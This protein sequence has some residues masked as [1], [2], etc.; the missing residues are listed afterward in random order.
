MNKIPLGN[1][2]EVRWRI[3]HGGQAESL[4]GLDLILLMTT[5]SGQIRQMPF[6]ISELNLITMPFEGK[7]QGEIGGYRLDLYENRDLESQYRIDSAP[8]FILV[9]HTAEGRRETDPNLE[10]YTVELEGNIEVGT[11]SNAVTFTPS[12]SAM[13]RRNKLAPISTRRKAAIPE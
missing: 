11:P 12:C 6:V 3:N 7:E 9:P 2:L 5:P 4:E 10:V 1:T 8:A 13:R